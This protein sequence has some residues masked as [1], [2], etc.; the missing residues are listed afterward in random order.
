MSVRPVIFFLCILEFPFK[1]LDIQA[2]PDA[3]EWE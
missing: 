2:A 1:T 3:S